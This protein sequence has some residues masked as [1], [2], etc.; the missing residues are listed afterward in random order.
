MSQ[1]VEKEERSVSKTG[2]ERDAMETIVKTARQK[3]D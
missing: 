2:G 1:D 3:E